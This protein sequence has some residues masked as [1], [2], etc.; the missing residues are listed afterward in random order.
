MSSVSCSDFI[1]ART[2]GRS[3]RVLRLPAVHAGGA[4][5]GGD[6]FDFEVSLFFTCVYFPSGSTAFLS[7]FSSVFPSVFRLVVELVWT[8]EERIFLLGP[9]FLNTWR[10]AHASVYGVFFSEF[11][12]FPRE[13]RPRILKSI[14]VLASR[15]PRQN[16][17]HCWRQTLPLSEVLFQAKAFESPD[18]NIITV[19]GKR[20][21]CAFAVENVTVSKLPATDIFEEL[22]HEGFLNMVLSLTGQRRV[23]RP[24]HGKSER[25]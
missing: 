3:G 2:V 22:S 4:P 8:C 5:E 16:C 15:A 20:S 14:L 7:L 24:L 18:R 19:G 9:I 11:H 10:H 17:R 6:G 23:V 13:G 12:V 25:K 1:I 21:H